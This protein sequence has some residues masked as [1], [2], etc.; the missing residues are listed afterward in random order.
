MTKA[1]EHLRF[2]KCKNSKDK[3]RCLRIWEQTAYRLIPMPAAPAGGSLTE[4]LSDVSL[5]AKSDS[6]SDDWDKEFR[7]S[8]KK[9]CRKCK[10]ALDFEL[11]DFRAEW[12]RVKMELSLVRELK[13]PLCLHVSQTDICI[14][15]FFFTSG[16]LRLSQS[17]T[18]NRL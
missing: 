13:I 11:S 14:L 5:N 17:A 10:D 16:K 12:K 2:P 18:G 7:L 8:N 6:E 4:E 3:E 1:R 9:V 15:S